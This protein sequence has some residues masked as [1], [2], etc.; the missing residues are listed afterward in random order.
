MARSPA[1]IPAGLQI[2]SDVRLVGFWLSRWAA[3]EQKGRQ[4][5]I[6]D[7]LD[8]VRKK[9]FRMPD[10]DEVPWR[11]DTPIETLRN[12]VAGTLGGRRNKRMFVFNEN[13][14]GQR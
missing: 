5:A 1:P 9:T 10:V 3:R 13:E 8:M 11:W 6:N 14:E 12:A 2:F 7:I 4:H